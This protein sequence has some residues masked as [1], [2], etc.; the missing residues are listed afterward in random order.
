MDK[1][2][3]KKGKAPPPGKKDAKKEEAH[4]SKEAETFIP[5]SSDHYM[6]EIRSYLQKLEGQTVKEELPQHGGE[7]NIRTK[8]EKEALLERLT[9]STEDFNSQLMMSQTQRSDMVSLQDSLR[10]AFHERFENA[11]LHY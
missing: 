3:D 1:K 6:E 8:E 4:E 10:E 2:N 11:S 5:V 7:V 9:L